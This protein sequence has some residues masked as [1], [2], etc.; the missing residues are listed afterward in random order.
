MSDTSLNPDTPAPLTSHVAPDAAK[1]A[2]DAKAAADAQKSKQKSSHIV[3]IMGGKPANGIA[4]STGNDGAV[5]PREGALTIALVETLN[6]TGGTHPGTD[7]NCV[8]R[9]PEKSEI[10]D[11]VEVHCMPG[12]NGNSAIVHPNKKESIGTLPVSTGDNAGTGVEVP[13]SAGRS[14]RKVSATAWQVL[15]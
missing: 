7:A 10:G 1:D 6:P 14:F 5:I 15:A 8:A 4:Y 12:T 2:A 9:L 3:T 13:A 11:M